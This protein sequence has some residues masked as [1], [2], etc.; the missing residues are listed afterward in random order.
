[1]H[2]ESKFK[3][4]LRFGDPWLWVMPPRCEKDRVSGFA[5]G[6]NVF[7]PG[8]SCGCMNHGFHFNFWN[9]GKLVS[10]IMRAE[11]ICTNIHVLNILDKS[12]I[13]FTEDNHVKDNVPC[14]IIT[15]RVEIVENQNF[16]AW[17]QK[18]IFFIR[19]I[20]LKYLLF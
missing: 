18:N 4:L 7:L 16:R 1:M 2:K 14:P 17:I 3:R 15:I 20:L 13:S 11:F 9:E 6:L 5:N 19:I 10:S 8:R 12:R